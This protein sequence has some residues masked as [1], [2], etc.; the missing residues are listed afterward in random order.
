M[1]VALGTPGL[2]G[3]KNIRHG[4]NRLEIPGGLAMVQGPFGQLAL[5]DWYVFALGKTEYPESKRLVRRRVRSARAKTDGRSTQK[6]V[7]GG[8]L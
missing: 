8:D 5:Q 1:D 7:S 4:G 6:T 2:R 3:K